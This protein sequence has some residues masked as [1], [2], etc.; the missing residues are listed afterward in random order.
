[1]KFQNIKKRIARN[2]RNGLGLNSVVG[3]GGGGGGG[4]SAGGDTR[5]SPP[6]GNDI[7][8]TV[9]ILNSLDLICEGPIGGFMNP[10][11]QYVSGFELLQSVY[12]NDTVV[13]EPSR[14][15]GDTIITGAFCFV[16][17][18]SIPSDQFP[19]SKY[20]DRNAY[21]YRDYSENETISDVLENAEMRI[22]KGDR[23]PDYLLSWPAISNTM[24]HHN[25]LHGSSDLGVNKHANSSIGEG[26]VNYGLYNP[27]FEPSDTGPK[28]EGWDGETYAEETF[29][30]DKDTIGFT[31]N[32]ILEGQGG[33]SSTNSV[34]DSTVKF[35]NTFYNNKINTGV[36]LIQTDDIR[37]LAS[38]Y[39]VK[40]GIYRRETSVYGTSQF[41]NNNDYVQ[42]TA[43]GTYAETSADYLVDPTFAD[44]RKMIPCCIVRRLYPNTMWD[45]IIK[46]TEQGYVERHLM[47][48][49]SGDSQIPNF[50]GGFSGFEGLDYDYRIEV[51]YYTDTNR[52]GDPLFLREIY[53][54]VLENFEED[55]LN[56]TYYASGGNDTS[57]PLSYFHK[58]SFLKSGDTNATI[59]TGI[60]DSTTGWLLKYSEVPYYKRTEAI[61]SIRGS[62]IKY[63]NPNELLT[64]SVTRGSPASTWRRFETDLLQ[65]KKEPGQTRPIFGTDYE[66]LHERHSQ[67]D[68]AVGNPDIH[69][70]GYGGAPYIIFFDEQ[71]EISNSSR[72]MALDKRSTNSPSI[73]S[74]LGFLEFV[75]GTSKMNQSGVVSQNL[76]A[77]LE[78]TMMFN[79]NPALYDGT[80]GNNDGAD[81]A[82]GGAYQQ[83]MFL[84]YYQTSF[85]R[86]TNGQ[87]MYL[88]N[89][90]APVDSFSTSRSYI[91]P[92][93]MKNGNFI[94]G[95]DGKPSISFISND[96]NDHAKFYSTIEGYPSGLVRSEGGHQRG[97]VSNDR[98]YGSDTSLVAGLL[99][100]NSAGYLG[101][102]GF[103]F[104]NV[105]MSA[106]N[107][108]EIQDTIPNFSEA[109]SE[110]SIQET[111]FG[112][113]DF[114]TNGAAR[115]GDGSRDIRVTGNS[116][117]TDYGGWMLNPPADSDERSYTHVINR[118]EVKK[119]EVLLKI[120]SLNDTVH[121]GSW[122][123]VQQGGGLF[124][125][126]DVIVIQ[127]SNL[128]RLGTPIPTQL[129]IQ[130]E[131][132]FEGRDPIQTQLKAYD[133]IVDP[134]APYITKAFEIDLPSYNEIQDEFPEENLNTIKE[135]VKR[136]IR[137]RKL[138]YET[139][140]VLISRD[141]AV[142]GIKE[143]VD[144]KFS[145]PYSAMAA[146]TVDSRTFVN[147]PQRS[148]DVRMKKCFVPSNYF[149]LTTFGT[150]KR[151]IYD[152]GNIP[153]KNF[154]IDYEGS[155]DFFEVKSTDV[156]LGNETYPFL[157]YNQP[158][159][160]EEEDFTMSVVLPGDT[161][162]GSTG[163]AIFEKGSNIHSG[164]GLGFVSGF[165][166]SGEFFAEKKDNFYKFQ[167]GTGFLEVSGNQNYPVHSL[168]FKRESSIFS[169]TLSGNSGNGF[170]L[171]ESDS[172]TITN[173]P[174]DYFNFSGNQLY[175]MSRGMSRK[176]FNAVG[177]RSLN[178]YSGLPGG[179]NNS[180]FFV[181][182]VVLP[183]DEFVSGLIDQQ[184][185]QFPSL[186]FSTLDIAFL[187][188]LQ[189]DNVRTP[190]RDLKITK[191]GQ[192]LLEYDGTI[193]GDGL[194][195][196]KIDQNHLPFI[197]LEYAQTLET[198]ANGS[199]IDQ[200]T[201]NQINVGTTS[202]GTGGS[203]FYGID[204][205][206]LPEKPVIYNGDW[207]GS[208]KFEW[209]DNPAWILYD[210]MINNNY[211]IGEFLDNDEDIDIFNLYK[212]GRYCD[213]VDESGF[214]VGL[215]D[216][217][218][219]LEPR[220]SCNIL[221]QES[222]NAFDMLNAV[223]SVF[224]GT[225]YW[226][227]GTVN[228]FMDKPE[229]ISAV[230]NNGNVYDG[231][232][233]YKDL[234]KNSRFNRVEIMF[235]DKY[236]EFK[237]KKEYV[238][239]EESIRKYGVLSYEEPARGFTTR[240]QARRYA[241]HILYS[242]L[243]ETEMV[244][245]RTSMQ[246]LLVEPGDIIQINDELK[247]FEINYAKVLDVNPNSKTVKIEKNIETGQII[248][249][250]NG[251]I[252]IQSATGSKE[253]K[254]LYSG[255][256]FNS[257]KISQ[258][259]LDDAQRSQMVKI[260]ITGII[261]GQNHTELALDQN[262]DFISYLESA[263][264]NYVTNVLT[265]N[266]NDDLYK[267]IQIS[268][269]D[270][271]LYEIVAKEYNSGKFELIESDGGLEDVLNTEEFNIGVPANVINKPTE[272][273]SFSF[274]T[275]KNETLG[276]DLTGVIIG[277]NNGTEENYRVSV[278]KP[279]GSY[280][281]KN[282]EKLED[283]QTKFEFKNLND[284]GV[285]TLEV[286]SLKNPES[287][288]TK[289]QYF[290]IDEYG[291]DFYIPYFRGVKL[292]SSKTSQYSYFQN[293]GYAI[294]QSSNLIF[295][296]DVRDNDNKKY[297]TSENKKIKTIISASGRD[298]VVKGCN[299]S[300]FEFTLENNRDVFGEAQ[301]NLDFEFCILENEKLI[302]SALFS[303]KNP[304]PKIEQINILSNN[305]LL[306]LEA[307]INQSDDL[308]GV[309]VY[310]GKS[311]DFECS[312]NSLMTYKKLTAE[313]SNYIFEVDA[314]TD[315][316]IFYKFAP[317][318][319]FGL[320]DIYTGEIKA[321]IKELKIQNKINTIEN[322]IN[323]NLSTSLSF[324]ESGLLDQSGIKLLLENPCVLKLGC[325]PIL[326]SS[327]NIYLD[328]AYNFEFKKS[329]Y[330]E[331]TL[332]TEKIEGE[333]YLSGILNSGQLS[334]AYL[335]INSISV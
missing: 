75:A 56:G 190:F 55:F 273:L 50:T 308:E 72:C 139:D 148:F 207:D 90:T 30:Y 158:L 178:V 231:I 20:Y 29:T 66:F 226:A 16:K 126:P 80:F 186:V 187:F 233:E 268:P 211:G 183:T 84:P 223:A 265:Q 215:S 184:Q 111:L 52:R 86:I 323:T 307:E 194:L 118:S 311:G 135:K 35:L 218:G 15:F 97:L 289:K 220:Y 65:E 104:P 258:E 149:P 112:P 210:L 335:E 11:D 40:A 114:N 127:D 320:G 128:S 79:Q 217:K 290:Q 196:S 327:L 315:E 286:T 299:L 188:F 262:N 280:L 264:K 132:G 62:K 239:D 238:E 330:T 157:Q 73:P 234:Y 199:R 54:I 119:V 303:V 214:F 206:E 255:I 202:V 160:L 163:L 278:Y 26:G 302:N 179:I 85:S 246:S 294:S 4:K 154:E 201:L 169:L 103:N 167:A 270:S 235:Q 230:F 208:F 204:P 70:Y 304:S 37:S 63:R 314:N 42:L 18:K 60:V 121:R 45:H 102:K 266:A 276:V 47:P 171:L 250:Q 138:S 221:F 316:E 3:A 325:Y 228:F 46:Q 229:E 143:I 140:S 161:S 134:S 312:N 319:S 115:T 248:T 297:Q 9:Q 53:P 334:G 99:S 109:S 153:L 329:S 124:E 166:R 88:V 12:L 245:F 131:V 254:D 95:I 182:G 61:E 39:L 306:R 77:T 89:A 8:E 310:T 31:F 2:I 123:S 242:N 205:I 195:R 198:N 203:L 197:A 41:F 13:M 43:A 100:T 27:N 272:P 236:D 237:V 321:T 87:F 185:E 176:Y 78:V 180:G 263:S 59:E 38:G 243:L 22:K 288:Q 191:T 105:A 216:D 113:F 213:S 332:F 247:S 49:F 33:F 317:K 328:K 301:R 173:V 28:Y 6:F 200:Y 324:N 74:N 107:G 269:S 125:P 193:V 305:L 101:Y 172:K 298:P 284:V 7:F 318:D 174:S 224:H 91:G 275:G 130:A 192:T 279:N 168:E 146:V 32:F 36:G 277:Q 145:Y 82:G 181:G 232:F 295:N 71:G 293:S 10:F 108:E 164:A 68:A 23:T 296:I 120:D 94:P 152:S 209:T 189:F 241:K 170:E 309:Y 175:L 44:G 136:Y 225:A 25:A 96:F 322:Q 267:V 256:N 64:I 58:L 67:E 98:T 69:Y 253:L 19:S 144:S 122:T 227:N 150:D 292:N 51:P 14:D 287:S 283:L 76:G 147:P 5:L 117:T 281:T 291:K 129:Y 252:F 165:Q 300:N 260:P 83:N 159:S 24:V 274:Q 151:F 251:G 110:Y 313:K 21:Y 212:I 326:D 81:V 331:K 162:T 116:L 142:E 57:H 1:M 222:N 271:N 133:G 141:V 244:N 285:Y 219:G 137:I 48:R 17:R 34:T 240:S 156:F 177:G 261:D 249:G 333:Y 282:F 92:L 257:L 93:L 106:R 155:T 259:D